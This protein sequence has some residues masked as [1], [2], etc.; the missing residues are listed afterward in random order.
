MELG[1]KDLARGEVVAVRRLAGER[2]VLTRARAAP[3]LRALLDET[4]DLMLA[5]S[6]P[7]VHATIPLYFLI[8]I[9]HLFTLTKYE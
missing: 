7:C 4:H 2:R 5:K 1:P 9:N 3:A 8:I 6:V